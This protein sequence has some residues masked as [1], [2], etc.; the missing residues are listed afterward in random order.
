MDQQRDG[1]S[2]EDR[3]AFLH[4]SLRACKRNT[5]IGEHDAPP[6]TLSA[7]NRNR[8]NLIVGIA[9]DDAESIRKAFCARVSSIPEIGPQQIF[10]QAVGRHNLQHLYTVPAGFKRFDFL[11]GV[12]PDGD[13]RPDQVYLAKHLQSHSVFR[14][15]NLG[16]FLQPSSYFVFNISLLSAFEDGS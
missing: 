3:N 14:W 8:F 7:N 5:A 6:R 9:G 12:Q 2:W 4:F 1:I 16:P 10:V 13:E 11:Q 15:Q